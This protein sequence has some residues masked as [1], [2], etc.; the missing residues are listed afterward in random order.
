MKPYIF[1]TN[2]Q[3]TYLY[4]LRD[5]RYEKRFVYLPTY[6]ETMSQKYFKSLQRED[7]SKDTNSVWI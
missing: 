5:G 7:R 4:V 3:N 1:V 6:F 2:D